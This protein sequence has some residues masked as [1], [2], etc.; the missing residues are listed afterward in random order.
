MTC[1][2]FCRIPVVDVYL[3][4]TLHKYER[5]SNQI[6]QEKIV[7][8]YVRTEPIDHIEIEAQK[9]RKIKMEEKKK[10]ILYIS[11]FII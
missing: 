8:V 5:V 2:S 3:M 9:N 10:C 7:Y 6:D 1:L 4:C 11:I